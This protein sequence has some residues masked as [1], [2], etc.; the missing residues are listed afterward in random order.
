MDI[1]VS[2]ATGVTRVTGVTGVTG[3]TWVTWVTRVTQKVENCHIMWVVGGV[4]GY[5]GSVWVMGDWA[6]G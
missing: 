5:G 6:V 3:V 1:G 2:G 4:C